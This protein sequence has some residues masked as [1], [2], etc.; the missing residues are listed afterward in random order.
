MSRNLTSDAETGLGRWSEAQ[1]V[2]ALRDGRSGGRVLVV[3]GMP[4]IYFHS[5]TAADATAIARYLKMLPPV[6]NRIPPLLRYGVIETVVA[7]LTGPLPQAPAARLT[8]ADQGR[9]SMRSG[10]YWGWVLGDL[11]LLDRASAVSHQLREAGPVP[12]SP[13]PCSRCWRSLEGSFTSGRS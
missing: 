8:Y 9:S 11:F 3:F 2:A 1:V 5:F 10:L 13:R 6:H 12:R 4:W 7:K